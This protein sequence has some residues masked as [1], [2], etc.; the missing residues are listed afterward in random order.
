M[1][2]ADQDSKFITARPSSDH[3]MKRRD[4]LQRAAWI[5]PASLFPIR[6]ASAAQDVSPVMT[7][8]SA[9]MADARTAELPEKVVQDAKHHILDTIAA[10]VSGSDLPPGRNA[11]QFALAQG[12]GQKVATVVASKALCGPIDAAFSNGELAHSDESDDDYTSD[13]AHPGCAVVPA[14]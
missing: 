1:M 7:K 14:R 11:I 13:G 9:Y 4:L 8:L 5:L 10:M 2:D 12:S 6:W 3:L